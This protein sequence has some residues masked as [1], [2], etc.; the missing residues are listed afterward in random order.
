MCKALY[1]QALSTGQ[2]LHL[3]IYLYKADAAVTVVW[4]R[5]SMIKNSKILIQKPIRGNTVQVE[6][7]AYASRG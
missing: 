1:S 5:I 7:I 6:K 4:E 3:R 2:R